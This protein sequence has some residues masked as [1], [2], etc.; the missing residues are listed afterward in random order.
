MPVS[1]NSSFTDFDKLSD[2]DYSDTG[3]NCS[4]PSTSSVGD[5]ERLGL[6]KRDAFA[7]KASRVLF[8]VFLLSA[9]AILGVVVYL[10]AR[11]DEVEEF[12]SQ[13]SAT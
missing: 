8:F 10:T 13:V 4:I 11:N 12:E 3:E 1:K 9:A 6:E 2:S 5:N 7:I